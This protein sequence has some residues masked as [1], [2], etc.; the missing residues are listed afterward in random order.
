MR[1]SMR[2]QG[3]EEAPANGGAIVVQLAMLSIHCN[4]E[5]FGLLPLQL[6]PV[7]EIQQS[8]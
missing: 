7:Y 4:Y 8:S 5:L 2:I 1:W 6:K 3:L